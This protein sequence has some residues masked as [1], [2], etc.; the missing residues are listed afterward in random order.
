MDESSPGGGDG[1]KNQPMIEG[2]DRLSRCVFLVCSFAEIERDHQRKCWK[3]QRMRFFRWVSI[4]DIILTL[5]AQR[6]DKLRE[7][8]PP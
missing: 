7:S 3:D 1:G 6:S 5:F 2:C 4:F 8:A